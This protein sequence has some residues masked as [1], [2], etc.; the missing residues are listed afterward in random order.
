MTL[1]LF[2]MGFLVNVTIDPAFK[3]V[4]DMVC[5][6][7][8]ASIDASAIGLRK[9]MRLSILIC[10][11]AVYQMCFVMYLRRLSGWRVDSRTQGGRGCGGQEKVSARKSVFILSCVD[12][13]I[14]G[15][16]AFA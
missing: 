16:N 5:E 7:L 14:S 6:W 2:G 4:S 15:G 13:N 9:D 10:M 11:S 3:H 12:H 8:N 1:G